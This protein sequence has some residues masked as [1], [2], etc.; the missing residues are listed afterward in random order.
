[1]GVPYA[2]VIGDPVA[3]SKSPAIHKFWLARLGL[4]Y[5]FRSNLVPP[6]QLAAYLETRR[7]DPSW[8]GCS[9]TLPHKVEAAR[10]V[11]QLSNTARFVGAVNCVTRTGRAG[12]LAGHNTDVVGFIAPLLPWLDKPHQ[13]RLAYVVGTGGAAA[14]VSVALDRQ[15]FVIVSIG[16]DQSKALALRHRLQLF[17]DHLAV[18]LASIAGPGDNDWSGHA[19]RL[20]LLVNATPLGMPGHPPL[21][22]DPAFFP[23]DALVYDLV[24][25][26]SET[27]LLRAARERGL[28]AI[29][30]LD[31]LIAQAAEAFELFF[32][33]P[34]PREHDSELRELLGQ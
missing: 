34:A 21:P 23:P 2:E 14:A 10:H 17:D 9:V 28:V 24:Y 7:R 6:A 25:T 30:G 31:M 32:M 1:M 3:H 11:D 4:A 18:D 33:A 16:R 5:D 27:P 15:G 22:V 13:M 12:K 20:V 26:P 29:G 19:D 8:C